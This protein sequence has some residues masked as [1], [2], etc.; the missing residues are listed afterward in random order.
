ME[1][2][3]NPSVSLFSDL[4]ARLAEALRFYGLLSQNSEKQK[5][6]DDPN[7]I[8]DIVFTTLDGV[9]FYFEDADIMSKSILSSLGLN[10]CFP[11]FSPL[12]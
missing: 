9:R 5:F 11:L 7:F 8:P 1:N 10:I 4:S 6:L 12:N 3:L 2:Q